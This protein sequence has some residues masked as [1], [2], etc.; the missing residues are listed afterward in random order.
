MQFTTL[1]AVLSLSA[2]AMGAAVASPAQGLRIHAKGE[3]IATSL[4]VTQERASNVA[5]RNVEKY[6][7]AHVAKL[8]ANHHRRGSGNLFVCTDSYFQGTCQNLQFT[9]GVCST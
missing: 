7:F 1:A 3:P 2:A 5:V 6:E 4:R 8:T 9:T